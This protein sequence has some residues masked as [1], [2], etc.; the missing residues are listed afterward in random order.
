MIILG[1]VAVTL[2]RSVS[3][4]N[5]PAG[6]ASRS[7]IGSGRAHIEHVPAVL[8]QVSLEVVAQ[9][10]IERQFAAD[11]PVVLSKKCQRMISRPHS[12]RNAVV[13][14]VRRADKKAGIVETDTG[15]QSHALERG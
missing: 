3:F 5:N 6:Q 2:P 1:E 8:S 13:A 15:R 9:A 14:G 12:C 7:R 11:L 4:K 10:V